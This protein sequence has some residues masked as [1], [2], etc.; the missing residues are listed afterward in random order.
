MFRIAMFEECSTGPQSDLGCDRPDFREQTQSSV[1]RANFQQAKL[2]HP[3]AG[4]R[5]G[6]L[7][8]R[9]IGGST[10][11]E[12]E[13]PVQDRAE[14]ALTGGSEMFAHKQRKTGGE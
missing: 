12:Q 10:P 11:V 5:N 3:L 13:Q 2:P 4:D 7:L 8:I 6:R 9:Q 14:A 1:I